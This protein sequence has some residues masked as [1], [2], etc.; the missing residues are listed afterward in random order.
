M[1]DPAEEN[2]P[3]PESRRFLTND[4]RSVNWKNAENLE[5]ILRHRNP[6]FP[7]AN[8]AHILHNSNATPPS[9]RATAANPSAPKCLSATWRF[10]G[11][12]GKPCSGNSPKPR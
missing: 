1:G 12:P 3:P 7:R 6:R 10:Q 9:L 8:S 5:T 2:D 4:L 11:T